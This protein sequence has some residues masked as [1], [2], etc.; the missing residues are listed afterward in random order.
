MQQLSLAVAARSADRSK[1]GRGRLVK[2]SVSHVC[3]LSDIVYAVGQNMVTDGKGQVMQK[4]AHNTVSSWQPAGLRTHISWS[5]CDGGPEHRCIKE[6]EME[7]PFC[8]DIA[9]AEVVS[10]PVVAVRIGVL[11]LL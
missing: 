5:I 8:A 9:A 2:E 10:D 11:D 4:K 1:G 3:H 6:G 7:L